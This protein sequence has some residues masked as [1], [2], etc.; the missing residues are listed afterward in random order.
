MAPTSSCSPHVPATALYG[1]SML[2]PYVC[3][4]DPTPQVVYHEAHEAHEG[5]TDSICG[6]CQAA[7]IAD[8]MPI[9][10]WAA[11]RCRA[12]DDD[13]APAAVI[14]PATLA[15]MEPDEARASLARLSPTQRVAQAVAQAAWLADFGYAVTH[16]EIL[17]SWATA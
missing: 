16:T 8:A 17:A 15:L 6:L 2:R 4:G 14:E 5:R 12:G 11:L 9:A 10:A 13:S 1:R 3:P 7:G